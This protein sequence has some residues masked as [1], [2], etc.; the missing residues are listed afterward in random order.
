M[1]LLEFKDHV[2]LTQYL[3][4][5]ELKNKWPRTSHF[6]WG[7]GM[8]NNAMDIR[9]HYWLFKI[10]LGHKL[11]EPEGLFCTYLNNIHTSITKVWCQSEQVIQT[12]LYVDWPMCV[13][14][15]GFQQL[16][17]CGNTSHL[18]IRISAVLTNLNIYS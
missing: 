15:K 9:D 2:G 1:L 6:W 16:T 14:S 5:L 4:Q 12:F 11:D 3:L 17:L 10:L 13:T 7:G 8:Q 18:I